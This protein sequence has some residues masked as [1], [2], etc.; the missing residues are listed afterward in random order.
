MLALAG[1][2]LAIPVADSQVQR[3][4]DSDEWKRSDRD[5][6]G[7][8]FS[9]E[10]W[11]TWAATEAV[12]VTTNVATHASTTPTLVISQALAGTS[13]AAD[14]TTSGQFYGKSSGQTSGPALGDQSP[15]ATS[16]SSAPAPSSA[17]APSS[18][19]GDGSWE[20]VVAKWRSAMGLSGLPSDSQLTSNA[21]KTAD[22]SV[23]GLHHQLNPGSMAQVLA[24]GEANNFEHV[25]VGGWLC[26]LPNTPGLNGVCAEQSKGWSYEGQT[27]HAEI[28]TSRSYHK[29]G[30]AYSDATGVWSCDLA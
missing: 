25:F 4:G 14:S 18:G 20:G 30:C 24:P 1:V 26:E 6:Q 9:S 23:G 22:E 17:S 2:T 21:Q 19:G 29:I 28:L 11:T 8:A 3:R 7:I 16:L 13:A 15:S 5:I 10:T 27:G 12:Y